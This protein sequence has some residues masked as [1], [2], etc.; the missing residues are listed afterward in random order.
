M[1]MVGMFLFVPLA[2]VIY[3]LI[4]E[5]THKNLDERLIDP[6]KLR[7]HPPVLQSHFQMKR[8]K[9]K[10]K[11]KERREE[12][13]EVREE[14]GLEIAPEQIR[15][16]VRTYNG[17]KIVDIYLIYTDAE[18][19]DM[20]LQ[21]EEVEQVCWM[22]GREV[23]LRFGGKNTR[24]HEEYLSCMQR[25]VHVTHKAEKRRRRRQNARL[26]KQGNQE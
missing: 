14:L 16:C 12:R 19:E 20:V 5:Y 2:S 15:N 23:L 11:R 24:L 17:H 13:R 7:E 8:Q 21:K 4:R 3:T 25:Y 6:D 22:S 10:E 18:I 9:R 26:A 1:G